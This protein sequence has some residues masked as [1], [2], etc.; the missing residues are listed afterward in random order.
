MAVENIDIKFVKTSFFPKC[1]FSDTETFSTVKCTHLSAFLPQCKFVQH[2]ERP[3]PFQHFV[4]SWEFKFSPWAPCPLKLTTQTH[5]KIINQWI[6]LLLIA[7]FNKTVIA[8]CTAEYLAITLNFWRQHLMKKTSIIKSWFVILIRYL[9]LPY[10]M[11]I[12]GHESPA[13]P[14]SDYYYYIVWHVIYQELHLAPSS[15]PQEVIQ[16]SMVYDTSV[17]NKMRGLD[18]LLRFTPVMR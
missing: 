16:L 3:V 2:T 13:E 6:L 7:P 8:N 18:A 14:C 11:E 9:R 17:I 4:R 1:F 5:T 12:V 15:A 10:K